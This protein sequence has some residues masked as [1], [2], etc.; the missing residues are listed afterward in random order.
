MQENRLNEP[1]HSKQVIE[2]LTVANEYCHFIE[3][4]SSYPKEEFIL[5]LSRILPLLYI[6]GSLIPE[7]EVKFPEATEHYVNEE[8]WEFLFNE[9]RGIFGSRDQFWSMQHGQFTEDPVKLS[10]SELLTDIYQDLKDFV[11]LYQSPMQE[12]KL[13]AVDEVKKLFSSRWGLNVTLALA[14]L[15]QINYP[16][17]DSSDESDNYSNL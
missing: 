3:N 16:A 15:H 17:T 7:V 13:N 6:K 1:Q 12:Q 9:L 10:I 14:E 4:A 5:F 2:I 8:H 11:V